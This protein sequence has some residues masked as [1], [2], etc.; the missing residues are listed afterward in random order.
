VGGW[1]NVES[2]ILIP[3]DPTTRDEIVFVAVVKNIGNGAAEPSKL[4][5]R[6]GGESAPPKY[7]VPGLG[8]GER[9][10]VQRS[11]KLTSALSYI[12]EARADAENVVQESNEG[13][14]T[15]TLSFPVKP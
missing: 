6:V 5:V 12:A 9:F 10:S 4:S 1:S 11:L 14:N 3:P 7:N 2:F 15:K 13:S 8:P